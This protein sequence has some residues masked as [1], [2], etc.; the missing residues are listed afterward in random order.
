MSDSEANLLECKQGLLRLYKVSSG[1]NG[2][3]DRS[4]TSRDERYAGK[5]VGNG[6]MMLGS[7][8]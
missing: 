5:E 3:P 4:C 6:G 7:V 2:A 8:A 1:R